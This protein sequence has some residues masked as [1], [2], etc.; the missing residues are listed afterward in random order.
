MITQHTHIFPALCNEETFADCDACSKVSHAVS[1]LEQRYSPQ[2]IET[3]VHLTSEA[4]KAFP[5]FQLIVLGKQVTFMV[6]S[7]ATSSVVKSGE[8]DCPP[9]PS[10]N[11]VYSACI[12]SGCE[13]QRPLRVSLPMDSPSSRASP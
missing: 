8:F 6:D 13:G 7:E 3:Y 2:V 12:R 10:G 5:T 9:K 11:H 4:Y 1:V